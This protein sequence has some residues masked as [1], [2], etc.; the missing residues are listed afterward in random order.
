MR[1]SSP[2]LWLALGLAG[3]AARL[4]LWTISI[5]SNDVYYWMDHAQNVALHGIASTYA[6]VQ[7]FNHPPLPGLYSEQAWW[8]ADEKDIVFARLIKLPGLLGEA[9]SL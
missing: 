2:W 4:L 6:H 3:V 1:P 5:G 7:A 9:I 8:W